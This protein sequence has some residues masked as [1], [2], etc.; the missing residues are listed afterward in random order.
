M[1][2]HPV[3]L[4]CVGSL[5]ESFTELTLGLGREPR[6]AVSGD[7]H[8][9]DTEGL[10]SVRRQRT[11]PVRARLRPAALALQRLW[12]AVHPHDAARQAGSDEARG[13]HALLHGPVPERDWERDRQAAGRVGAE[14]AA[15]GARPCAQSLP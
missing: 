3:L 15:L 11:D 2:C 9:G 5:S 6:T 4:G 1:L 10:P 12:A 7:G 14:R 13:D 8:G